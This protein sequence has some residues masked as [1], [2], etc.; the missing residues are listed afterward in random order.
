MDTQ[1]L[2]EKILQLAIQGKLVEQNPNDES[3]SE[4][5]KEIE[6]E[7]KKLYKEGKIRK[8][9]KLPPI[10]E[11]EKPFDIPE[12]WEWVRLGNIGEIIGGGTP[13]TSKKEYWEKGHIP[14]ITP[15]DLSGYKNK[16][17]EKGSRSI[18][19]I[20]LKKS[21][22]RLMPK[23]TV[24]FSSRAPIGYTVIAKNKISTNQGFKSCS[25]YIV[26]M[27]QYIYYFLIISAKKINEEATGT[28]FKEV[29]GKL[30]SQIMFSLPPLEEQKR[31]VEKIDRIF[32][33]LNLLEE[34]VK[35]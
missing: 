12:S 16:Y 34:S 32:N 28:T 20:G 35:N 6:I 30:V 29:S 25:P 9:K 11:E 8:P 5:L 31:I 21:S 22:A 27:N 24:I 7:K 26:E 1:K 17:I 15:A 2:K 10:K 19:E 3:A 14:W 13:K 33:Y 23:G 4:L 18:T